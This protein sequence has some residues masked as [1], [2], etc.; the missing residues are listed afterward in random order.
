MDFFI[1]FTIFS[2]VF[3]VTKACEPNNPSYINCGRDFPRIRYPFRIQ[4]KQPHH[5]SHPDFEL[6]FRQN[7]TYIHFPTY[8]DLIV[9]SISYNTRKLNLIDPKNCVPEV[10][11]N[12]NLSLT[13]F[14]YCYILKEYT[15]IN[16]SSHLSTSFVKVPC[17]SGSNHHVYIVETLISPPVSCNSVKTVSIPFSYS[18]YLFDNSFGLSLTW[19]LTGECDD[20]GIGCQSETLHNK[21]FFQVANDKVTDLIAFIFSVVTLFYAKMALYKVVDLENEKE[22][23]G[24][25]KVGKVLGEYEAL[26]HS[27]CNIKVVIQ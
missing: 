10:Y 16:C 22:K 4:G 8:G 24:E 2:Y 18:P 20:A 15:Y 12:L 3:L 7:K 1:F 14:S 27:K 19:N 26:N 9:K 21:G 25:I 5:S 6:F 23:L 13:P 17:L 11:L